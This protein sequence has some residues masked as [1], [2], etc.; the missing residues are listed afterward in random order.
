MKR[1]I[2]TTVFATL[3]FGCIASTSGRGW[4]ADCSDPTGSWINQLGSLLQIK[5]VN[6]GMLSGQ[7]QTATGAGGWF[8]LTG[9]L[10][11][12]APS[13][14]KDHLASVIS[15]TVRWGDIGSITAWAGSCELRKIGGNRERCATVGPLCAP[16][17]TALWH[18]VRP[19]S[20]YEWDHILTNEDV[21]IPAVEAAKE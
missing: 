7:Y 14:P 9:W 2:T 12:A 21:F 19:N 15:F 3:V 13:P 16:T 11:Q 4:A 1:S 18:L 6:A 8:P 5:S 17:I 10:N 20:E